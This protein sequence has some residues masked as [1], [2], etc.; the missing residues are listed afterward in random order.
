VLEL[1]RLL[2]PGCGAEILRL[3]DLILDALPAIREV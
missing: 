3:L 2:A 1:L